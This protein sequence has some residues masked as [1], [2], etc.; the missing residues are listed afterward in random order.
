MKGLKALAQAT[1]NILWN[2]KSTWIP[3]YY[4]IREDKVYTK[5]GENRFFITNLINPQTEKDIEKTVNFGLSLQGGNY[6]D[7]IGNA[8][9][10]NYGLRPLT[11]E[12][13]LNQPELVK[14]TRGNK[15]KIIGTCEFAKTL[16]D[17][18]EIRI[19]KAPELDD[20]WHATLVQELADKVNEAYKA[21]EKAARVGY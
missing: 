21:I 13:E 18:I 5:E 11:L 19:R 12:E 15:M 6:M 9:I 16:I 7:M 2:D 3:L 20:E 8:I 14:Q 4:S 17:T 10:N 1:Q